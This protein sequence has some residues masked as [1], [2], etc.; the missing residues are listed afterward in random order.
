VR[1]VG[2]GGRGKEGLVWSVFSGL[3]RGGRDWGFSFVCVSGYD[4]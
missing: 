1:G 3:D 2:L 4:R